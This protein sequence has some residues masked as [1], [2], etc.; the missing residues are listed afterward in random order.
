MDISVQRTEL[1]FTDMHLLFQPQENIGTHNFTDQWRA[2]SYETT[3]Y[4]GTMLA[5]NGG[6]PEDVTFSPNL[7]GWYKIYLSAPC[8]SVLSVKLSGDES[9]L[10]VSTTNKWMRIMEE[11]LWRCADMTGQSIVLTK[12][13]EALP[14][15]AMLAA[16]RFVPM[17]DQE[18]VQMRQDAAR[19][20]TK[21]IYATNDM[22]CRLYAAQ[23]YD[24]PDWHA[25][26]HG[27]NNSDVE[28]I[29]L[30]QVRSFV[31]DNMTPDV[32]ERFCFPRPGDRN[33]QE[34][35]PRFDYNR[36]LKEC[37]AIGHREGFRMSISLRMG[38]WGMGYPADQSYFDCKF[39]QDHP[40][41]RT[42]DRNGDEI[43]A[44]SYAYPEVRRYMI[45]ELLN[46]ARSGCDAV[47][48]IAHRG[49]PYV[50]F[51]K[52]V[53]DRFFALYGEYPYE[54]PLADPRLHQLHCQIMTEFFRDARQALD[55]E[56]GKG[57]VQIHLRALFSP[58]DTDVIGIDTEQLAREGLVDAIISYPLRIYEKLGGDIWQPGKEYR[59]DLQKYTEYVRHI[60]EP[61]TYRGDFDFK[62]PYKNYRGVLC[63]PTSQKERVQQWMQLEKDYG[64][65]IY[66][67]IL[68]RWMTP[69]E[70]KR[71][72]L[73]FY[74]YGAERIALWDTYCRLP[75]K[76]EW[77][78][79]SK[80]GHKEELASMDTGE[81][82]LYRHT[83]I[84]RLAG[85]D[86][87]R[88]HPSW[89]G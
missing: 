7:T 35:F 12:K 4:S 79:A 62:E 18:V 23:M 34:S 2:V 28:W 45:D 83:K 84:C 33:V 40:E 11:F 43:S 21:R 56:F 10:S 48:L 54:L 61:I 69:E 29:S 65:K 32:F 36:V 72:A 9:F 75:V 70:Y 26:V 59:I 5:C 82:E 50:L 19:T 14:R 71:R 89:G 30:E 67:E 3:D 58:F 51:E 22:H 53:A 39:M 49:V 88:Y 42:I 80:L 74:S 46:M 60:P 25:V 13:T 64:V 1:F 24:Y 8:G 47:A 85:Y 68:P 37:V 76:A 55:E 52:P 81:G 66:L 20:D 38:A 15:H 87:S 31:A 16:I 73:E 44:L 63:G 6:S 17:S 77:N 27:Y 41:L 57:K 86:I 78:F